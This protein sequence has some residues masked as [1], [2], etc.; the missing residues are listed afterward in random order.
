MT[1]KKKKKN[2]EDRCNYPKL[3]TYLTEENTF[4]EGIE[5]QVTFFLDLL[6]EILNV[7]GLIR[8]YIPR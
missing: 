1:L 8:R 6:I 4:T 3:S 7:Y 5:E 2:P